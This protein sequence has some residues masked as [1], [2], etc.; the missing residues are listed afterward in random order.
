MLSFG[1]SFAEANLTGFFQIGINNNKITKSGNPT[2][3]NK[4]EDTNANTA[5]NFTDVEDLGDG[6][7]VTTNI[8]LNPSISD[9]AALG[10]QTTYAALSG[11]FGELQAGKF[12]NDQFWTVVAGDATGYMGTNAAVVNL[13][14]GTSSDSTPILGTYEVWTSNQVRY[15]L[16]TFVQGLTLAYTNKLGGQTDTKYNA[17][18][19]TGAY[20][21]GGF[22]VQLT[23]TQYKADVGST[24]TLTGI[25]AS[26]DFG[27][28]KLY[29]LSTSAKVDGKGTVNGRNIGISVPVG[30]VTLMYNN[31]S[32]DGNLYNRTIKS[33]DQTSQDLGVTYAF[34]KRTTAWVL[35]TKYS[36]AT[37]GQ[38]TDTNKGK[39][40]SDSGF[41]SLRVMLTHSF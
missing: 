41:D 16:P 6:I 11:G 1:V 2:T 5:L 35:F 8:G 37:G 40:N 30:A 12:G 39:V 28:A 7:K 24:D 19:L 13:A 3:T 34:S 29:A 14:F 20:T 22:N 36:G 23:A 10:G 33:V 18:T 9:S 32:A 38:G 25:A 27:M 21:T 4:L 17:D 26:Y 15:Q 31:S